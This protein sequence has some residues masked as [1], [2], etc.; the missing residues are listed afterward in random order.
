MPS[1][2]EFYG[3]PV[4]DF[5]SC[6]D[7]LLRAPRPGAEKILAF[8]D[9][10]IGAICKDPRLLLAPLDDHMCH[11]GDGVFESVCYRER[12]IFALD[13]HLARLR[14][15]AE[16]LGIV[17]PVSFERIRELTRAVAAAGEEAHG[18]LRVFVSRGP[19]GFGVSAEE[20][21]RAG[22][23]VVA[24]ASRLPD[25][26]YY[27]KGLSAF[28]SKYPPK[29]DYL[30]VVKNTS[31]L[32]NVFMAAE[33]RERGM[34]VAVT[35]DENGWLG[36]AAIANV[37][38]IDEHGRFRSPGLQRVLAGT[39]LLEALKL[40]AERMPVIEGPID[41]EEIYRAR[42]ALL[43]TSATLCV[44]ITSFDGRPIGYGK[45]RG[46]PG[47]AAFWL[48][49]ALLKTMLEHGTPF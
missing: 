7:A 25:K 20:C 15:G 32:P 24:V 11:R 26:A 9:D 17:P 12:K 21:P 28:A 43:F 30:A 31:Y 38:I 40:A 49:D 3:V 13:R 48:K 2:P 16:K 18:D 44:A 1:S 29:Q 41:K 46:R 39:T 4:G 33:A 10:R 45:D 34:D 6:L 42:E 22:L 35:F 23:Y 5:K 47:P 36:E 14:E 19:G 37:A 8:Y 27:E